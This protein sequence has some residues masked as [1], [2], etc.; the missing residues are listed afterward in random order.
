MVGYELRKRAEAKINDIAS[1]VFEREFH[2]SMI[3]LS[4]DAIRILA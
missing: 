4:G 1:P 2:E 3:T